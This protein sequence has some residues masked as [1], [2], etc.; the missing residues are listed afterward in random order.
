[1]MRLSCLSAVVLTAAAPA[2]ACPICDTGTGQQVRAGILDD[3]FAFN[4][5]ATLLPF[6]ILIGI[7]AVIHF[8]GRIGRRRGKR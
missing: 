3:Q 8:G 7:V 2:L 1:M 4:L 5:V 6:P